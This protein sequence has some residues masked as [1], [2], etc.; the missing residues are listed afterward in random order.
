MSRRISLFI[1]CISLTATLFNCSFAA[2]Q[3][4]AELKTLRDENARLKTELESAN[5]K[6]EK[7]EKQIES[8][9]AKDSKE[10]Q[11]AAEDLF[12]VGSVWSGSRFY[13]QNGK[14]PNRKAQ[15]WSM[16]VT[17]RDGKKFKAEISFT[18]FDGLDKEISVAGSAPTTGK[19]AVTFKTEAK[20][21]FQQTFKGGLAGGQVSLEF[22]GTG[23]EGT[24]VFGTGDLK[25]K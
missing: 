24:R 25:R 17:E 7:L 3:E 15:P 16:K 19:G 14:Q 22:D 13:N 4:N 6:I 5:E 1:V 20:G 11:K 12:T 2:A 10:D 9:R 21:I 8:M 23:V 18:A